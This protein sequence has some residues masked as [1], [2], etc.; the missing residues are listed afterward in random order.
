MTGFMPREPR[1][2]GREL[3]TM[4]LKKSGLVQGVLVLGALEWVRT[5]LTLV[6]ECCAYG[7]LWGRLAIIIGLVAVFTGC[8]ALL[9]HGRSLRKYYGLDN[10][11]AGISNA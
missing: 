6:A 11:M 3:H 9:F 4:Q 10:R 5:L 8:S 2:V 7:L 1:I